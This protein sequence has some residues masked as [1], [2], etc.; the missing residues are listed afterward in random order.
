MIF[1]FFLQFF[2]VFCVFLYFLDQTSDLWYTFGAGDDDNPEGSFD[3]T[4]KKDF[5]RFLS[6]LQKINS[7]AKQT[8]TL[9]IY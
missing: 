3:F 8:A 6:L 5:F 1:L 4:K 9:L 2:L 7:K